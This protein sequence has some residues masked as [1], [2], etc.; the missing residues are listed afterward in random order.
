M[1][2]TATY[3][4]SKASVVPGL[5]DFN[6]LVFIS[7]FSEQNLGL[8]LKHPPFSW[9]MFRSNTILGELLAV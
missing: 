1:L 2:L 7:S 8:I 6:Y 9:L 5:G 4:F 3:S